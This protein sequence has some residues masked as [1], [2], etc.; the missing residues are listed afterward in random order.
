MSI[1]QKLVII[2]E[3][4]FRLV[5][6]FEFSSA[7]RIHV[8]ACIKTGIAERAQRIRMHLARPTQTNDSKIP[9]LLHS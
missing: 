1:L 4:F 7:G 9:F 5:I 8:R 3:S 2:A 6:C